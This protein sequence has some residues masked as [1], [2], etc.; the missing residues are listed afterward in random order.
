MDKLEEE[1]KETVNLIMHYAS[2]AG[3]ANICKLAK[4][5]GADVGSVALWGATYG[6]ECIVRLGLEWG[7]TC[8]NIVSPTL[9]EYEQVDEPSFDVASSIL[10]GAALNGHEH[11]CRLAKEELG[12]TNFDEFLGAA[13]LSRFKSLCELAKEWGATNFNYMLYCALYTHNEELCELAKEWGAT[14][15]GVKIEVGTHRRRC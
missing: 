8:Q 3:N 12:A 6:H 10:T 11:I 4:E 2:M 7:Y 9:S 1:K 13:T 5:L 14:E 15:S